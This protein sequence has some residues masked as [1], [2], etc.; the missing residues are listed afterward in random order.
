MSLE[1]S[2]DLQ[3]PVQGLKPG[4]QGSM[5]VR[6]QRGGCV[7]ERQTPLHSLQLLI[8]ADVNLMP[9]QIH[10]GPGIIQAIG[11]TPLHCDAAHALCALRLQCFVKRWCQRCA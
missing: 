8:N 2:S 3:A 5:D 6:A 7:A 4:V 9:Q 10:L 1:A 11:L